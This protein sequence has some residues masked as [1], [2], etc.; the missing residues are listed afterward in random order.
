M[1]SPLAGHDATAPA[2]PVVE[3]PVVEAAGEAGPTVE[4]EAVEQ[5]SPV[6]QTEVEQI[7]E[8]PDLADEL[9]AQ[10]DGKAARRR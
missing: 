7:A 2:T 6:G 10:S 1:F 3:A 8:V 4:V 5:S 9:L